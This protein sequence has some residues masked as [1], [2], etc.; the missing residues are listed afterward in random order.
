MRLLYHLAIV[1]ADFVM[2][3]SMC[4]GLKKRVE[5]GSRNDVR[6]ARAQGGRA[7]DPA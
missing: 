2:G 5:P 7:S 4:L 6:Q 3:R 1:P